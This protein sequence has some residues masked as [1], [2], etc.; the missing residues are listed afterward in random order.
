MEECQNNIEEKN[1]QLNNMIKF[2]MI[3]L[4]EENNI[5]QKDVYKFMQ[6]TNSVSE[7]ICEILKKS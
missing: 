1:L 7:N 4:R 3:S 2:L 6:R 5:T